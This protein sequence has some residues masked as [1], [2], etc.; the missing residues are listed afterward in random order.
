M[1]QRGL[2]A[3]ES[4]VPVAVARCAQ[5]AISLSRQTTGWDSKIK[6]RIDEDNNEVNS[7]P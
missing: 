2:L 4:G 5:P 1:G 6:R 7:Q 3:D